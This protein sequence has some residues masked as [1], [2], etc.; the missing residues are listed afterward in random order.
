MLVIKK[1]T[2][3]FAK[4]SVKPYTVNLLNGQLAQLV[5]AFASH[6]KG[7]R[8]ES[9]IVHHY[10]SLSILINSAILPFHHSISFSPTRTRAMKANIT[11]KMFHHKHGSLP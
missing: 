1:M 8:F 11:I 9:A 5:R 4:M 6:A 2:G 7:H 3:N 10:S